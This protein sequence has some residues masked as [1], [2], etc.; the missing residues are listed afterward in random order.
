MEQADK[1]LIEKQAQLEI[2][3]AKKA[4]ERKKIAKQRAERPKVKSTDEPPKKKTKVN[5]GIPFTKEDLEAIEFYTM[6]LPIVYPT[7]NKRGLISGLTNE[8]MNFDAYPIIIKEYVKRKDGPKPPVESYI[9]GVTK[10]S[11]ALI[12]LK[13]VFKLNH[14]DRDGGEI[15]NWPVYRWNRAYYGSKVETTA[16][17]QGIKHY[18]E[19][20]EQKPFGGNREVASV[21]MRNESTLLRYAKYAVSVSDYLLHKYPGDEN[22]NLTITMP[23][24]TSTPFSK[25]YLTKMANAINEVKKRELNAE[26]K[27][28]EALSTEEMKEAFENLDDS[29]EEDEDEYEGDQ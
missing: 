21:N 3:Q 17:L 8:N 13:L 18:L 11:L 28:K 6:S 14:A 16:N 19:L 2:E 4:I 26:A 22:H 5:P 29:D 12:I 24:R 27:A 25:D 23:L 20:L 7:L 10:P 9:L 1:E 15:G